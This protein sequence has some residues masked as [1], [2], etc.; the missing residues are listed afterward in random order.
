MEQACQ[1]VLEAKAFS[2]KALKE[3]LEWLAKQ[4]AVPVTPETLPAHA[5]IRGQEY[6]Q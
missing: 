3:E 2:Y 6:Y 5:N 1:S 4:A